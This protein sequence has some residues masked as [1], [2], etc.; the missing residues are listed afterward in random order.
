MSS[1]NEANK[2]HQ[3]SSQ[4]LQRKQKVELENLTRR[5]ET[6]IKEVKKI[7][8]QDIH[9]VREQHQLELAEEVQKKEAALDALRQSLEK[10]QRITQSEAQRLEA[11]AARKRTDAMERSQ[12][13]IEKLNN[14]HNEVVEE[15]NIRQNS[16]LNDIHEQ[17]RSRENEMNNRNLYSVASQE[18]EWQHKIEQQRGQFTNNFQTENQ[19]FETISNK[20]QFDN[21]NQLKQTH[22]LHEQRM[23]DMN[24]Q[25]VAH[26]EKVTT[27]NQKSLHEK[28]TFFEKKY[29]TQLNR[30]LAS[31][32]HLNELNTKAIDQA[33]DSLNKRVE[34]EQNRS[35]DAFFEFTGIKTKLSEK[36]DSYQV[37]VQ[38]PEYAKESVLLTANG[39]EL[40]L[41]ANRRYQDERKNE[42]GSLQKVNKVESLVSRI[43][44]GQ[45]L[46][47]KHLKKEWVDGQL[48]F[49]IKKA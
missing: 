25:H 26:E 4:N 32:K 45:V 44:V 22:S 11:H 30:H 40:V 29:Q 39:K 21:K 48:L 46:D 41:T 37:T 3:A 1:V 15:V 14:H 12:A 7:Q 17:A 19:K 36:A 47:P 33:K 27:H 28:E 6:N 8:D 5:H 38:I 35:G 2:F 42:D 49:T 20:Q 31:E 10:T 34:I 23:N 18:Q 9:Q 13:E 16:T 43:P 24:K